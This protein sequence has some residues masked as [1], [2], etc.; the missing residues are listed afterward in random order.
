[1]RAFMW[2][3]RC[4]AIAASGLIALVLIWTA[5]PV[6]K[7]WLAVAL[8]AAMYGGFFATAFTMPHFGGR[9]ADE[10]GVPP[11]GTVNLGGRPVVLDANLTVFG[12]LVLIL[13]VA[14]LLIR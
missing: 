6:T 3:G 7:L 1:M 4:P 9:L 12:V 5:G 8:A 14:A 10:N 11:L 13:V 2:C